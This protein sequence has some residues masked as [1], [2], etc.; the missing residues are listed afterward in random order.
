MTWGRG[1][2]GTR[3]ASACRHHCCRRPGSGGDTTAPSS[4]RPAGVRAPSG[5]LGAGAGTGGTPQAPQRR[6]PND[7]GPGRARPARPMTGC[8]VHP[9]STGWSP[10]MHAPARQAT[11]LAARH[12]FGLLLG[13]QGLLEGRWIAGRWHWLFKASLPAR[14]AGTV[15]RSIPSNPLHH[16]SPLP[17]VQAFCPSLHSDICRPPPASHGR[18]AQEPS[19]RAAVRR[20]LSRPAGRCRGSGAGRAGLLQPQARGVA[21]APPPTAACRLLPGPGASSLR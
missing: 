4:R 1:A 15:F 12:C 20:L 10:G 9:L 11:H 13:L 6:S 19:G 21:A 17:C 7:Q 3:R 18:A 14:L 5:G 8:T 2:G 16:C